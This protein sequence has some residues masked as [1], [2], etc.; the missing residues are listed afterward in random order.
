MTN[1][2]DAE[3]ALYSAL[4]ALREAY[5]EISSRDYRKLSRRSPAL[6]QAIVGVIAAEDTRQRLV[7]LA[8]TLR[9]RRHDPPHTDDLIDPQN[10]AVEPGERDPQDVPNVAL[11]GDAIF[12]TPM[13]PTRLKDI[14]EGKGDLDDELAY[15]IPRNDQEFEDHL[16]VLRVESDR[17]GAGKGVA[18]ES[19]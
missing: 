13:H 6:Q 12:D 10:L 5:E 4:E 1:P 19:G 16:H 15:E 7:A 2:V 18:P 14:W 11:F 8:D 9:S 17:H 3:K